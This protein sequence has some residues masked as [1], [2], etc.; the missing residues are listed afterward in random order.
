MSAAKGGFYPEDERVLFQS[1]LITLL[2]LTLGGQ[3]REFILNISLRVTRSFSFLNDRI[4]RK[5]KKDSIFTL[6]KR[7]H[8]GKNTVPSQFQIGSEE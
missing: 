1:G 2:F 5:Q 7:R 4:S 3:R 8:Q 6:Q